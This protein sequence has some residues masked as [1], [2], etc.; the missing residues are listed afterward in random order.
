MSDFEN[1]S[2]LPA[3]VIDVT[4]DAAPIAE[5]D[6]KLTSLAAYRRRLALDDE[7]SGPPGA[8]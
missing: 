5:P 3:P 4:V 2:A 7:P 8:P 6:D 1:Q